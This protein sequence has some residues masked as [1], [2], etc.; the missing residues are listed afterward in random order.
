G[1][2][3]KTGDYYLQDA[4]ILPVS[5]PA[6]ELYLGKE[7]E[8]SGH[9]VA[10]ILMSDKS[11]YPTIKLER[12]TDSL[13]DIDCLFPKSDEPELKKLLPGSFVTISSTC[14][15]RVTHGKD[16]NHVRFDNCRLI[17]TTGPT[18]PQVSR[19]PAIK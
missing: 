13:V 3:G 4:E 14:S 9:V 10:L 1:K 17:S 2:E 19:L 11:E 15:G 16:Q 12:P 6:D 8:L 5:P 7:I 18:S